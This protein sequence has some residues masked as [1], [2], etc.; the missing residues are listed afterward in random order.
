MKEKIKIIHLVM[1]FFR[2]FLELISLLGFF[3]TPKGREG[4]GR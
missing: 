3:K 4:N 2:T 1:K